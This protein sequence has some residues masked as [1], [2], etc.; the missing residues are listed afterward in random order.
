MRGDLPVG[1]PGRSVSPGA[2]LARCAHAVHYRL[3]A[4]RPEGA[5]RSGLADGTGF[6]CG[7]D[8]DGRAPSD[9]PCRGHCR[10]SRVLPADLTRPLGRYGPDRRFQ[11]DTALYPGARGADRPVPAGIP[12]HP[13]HPLDASRC[14]AYRPQRQAMEVAPPWR[15]PTMCCGACIRRAR[16]ATDA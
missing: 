11:P 16:R 14:G 13:G 5:C 8:N 10:T 9:R 12:R 7:H 2:V 15:L 4:R 3:V 1:D 6:G